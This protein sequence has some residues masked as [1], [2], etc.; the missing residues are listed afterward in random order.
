MF[1]CISGGRWEQAQ[2]AVAC[3]AAFHM[4]RGALPT[5]AGRH[6]RHPALG[7]LISERKEG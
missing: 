4:R 5:V 2:T 1:G 3:V 7:H 6:G